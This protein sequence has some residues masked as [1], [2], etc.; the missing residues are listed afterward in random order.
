MLFQNFTYPYRN[1]SELRFRKLTRIRVLVPIFFWIPSLE[2]NCISII[3]FNIVRH[4]QIRSWRKS[5]ILISAAAIITYAS[6]WLKTPAFPP[7]TSGTTPVSAETV[8]SRRWKPGLRIRVWKK[9]TLDPDPLLRKRSVPVWISSVNHASRFGSGL[10][11][12]GRS[13]F[14]LAIGSESVFYREA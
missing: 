6:T 10:V 3:G 4:Y 8:L 14:F 13:Q 1:L 5:A 11:L 2:S 7:G 9:K 12:V